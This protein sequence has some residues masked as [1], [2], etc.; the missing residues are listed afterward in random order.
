MIT[1]MLHV[2]RDI[3]FNEMMWNSQGKGSG[4][5]AL[6]PPPSNE[7]RKQ[8]NRPLV[9]YTLTKR[10]APGKP[11]KSAG[12]PTPSSATSLKTAQADPLPSQ[13]H[14]SAFNALTGY[15]SDS[16]EEEG[17]AIAGGDLNFFSLG[18]DE[19]GGVPTSSAVNNSTPSS[20]IRISDSGDSSEKTVVQSSSSS[21]SSR[22][23]QAPVTISD[24]PVSSST[25]VSLSAGGDSLAA[26]TS[27]PKDI[28]ED[29]GSND[30]NEVSSTVGMPQMD[31]D[32]P[33]TF[34]S[35][36]GG[37]VWSAA[38]LVSAMVP[39][40]Y[41]ASS[42]TNSSAHYWQQQ[43]HYAQALSADTDQVKE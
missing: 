27:P 28:N 31:Q 14:Q 10:P 7:T 17:R 26:E 35:S 2:H 15:E 6:L 18:G 12:K 30:E 13:K 43:Q 29:S 21:L 37:R 34:S 22:P 1:D 19:A 9:P 25:S 39:E 41:A 40:M 16:D 38:P 3:L 24:S 42:S 32:A 4:L 36:V 5:F 11:N 33:L 8:T 20:E 23:D